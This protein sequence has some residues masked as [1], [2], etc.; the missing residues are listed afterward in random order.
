[1]IKNILVAI[2]GSAD[3]DA[4]RKYAV[5]LALKIHA[6]LHLVHIVDARLF[7]MPFLPPT[8]VQLPMQLMTSSPN[9]QELLTERGRKV[10]A[11]AEARCEAEELAATSMLYIGNPAQILSEIQSRA[12]LVVLGRQGEHA[13]QS[14]GMTGSTT[15]RFVRRACRPALVVPR[16]A[17]MPDR[18]VV[19]VDGSPHAYRALQEASELANALALPLVIVAVAENPADRAHAEELAAEA[20]SLVRAHD[21]AAAT[22]VAEGAPAQRILEIAG[23]TSSPLVIMGAYGHGWIYDRLIGSTAARILAAGT[24]PVLFVR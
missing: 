14:P 15:D 13:Q 19:P 5:Q 12:E 20:H 4:A 6:Q 17:E 24:V 18:L 10:L 11:E 22:L 1:M 2:D 7:D 8:S 16:T 21:C 9:L 23:Q 3:A